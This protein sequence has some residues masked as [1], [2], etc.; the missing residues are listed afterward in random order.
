MLRKYKIY[1]I[2]GDKHDLTDFEIE[3]LRFLYENFTNLECIEIFGKN[4]Y[5]N[6][7][8]EYIFSIKKYKNSSQI[9]HISSKI[10]GII[11][12]VTFNDFFLSEYNFEVVACKDDTLYVYPK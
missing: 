11:Y 10:E 7:N 8:K 2:T 1:L 4:V 3:Q 5:F 12:N 6:K 9:L